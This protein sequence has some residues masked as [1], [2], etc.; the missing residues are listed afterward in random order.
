MKIP[1]RVKVGAMIYDV[2]IVEHPIVVGGK[3]CHGAIAYAEQLIEIRDN[4]FHS[5][6]M[7]TNTFWHELFHAFANERGLDWGENNELYTEELAKAM[8][9]FCVDN[10]LEFKGDPDATG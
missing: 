6:Q 1:N 10:Q 2:K 4:A 5:E 7:Q 3:E 9:A 8:H